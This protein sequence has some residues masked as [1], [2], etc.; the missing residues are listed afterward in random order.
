MKKIL[1]VLLGSALILSTAA[2]AEEKKADKA[3]AKSETKSE[4][5]AKKSKKT[6]ADKAA[7]PAK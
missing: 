4:K 6:T 3:S 7:T 5:K 1:S 2:F